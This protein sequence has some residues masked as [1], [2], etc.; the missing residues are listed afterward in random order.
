[1][2]RVRPHHVAVG[3]ALLVAAFNSRTVISAVAPIADRLEDG[4]GLDIATLSIIATL[5]P[6]SFAVFAAVTPLLLRHSGLERAMAM[7]LGAIVLGHFIRALAIDPASFIGG[8]VIGLAGVGTANVLLP[9]LVRRHYGTSVGLLTG[10]YITAQSLGTAL[11]A[12]AGV[13]MSD[14]AGWRVAMGVWAVVGTVG[15]VLWVVVLRGRSVPIAGIAELDPE[16]ARPVGRVWRAPVAWAIAGLF[17]L[18]AS[19][20]YAM[21]S[22]L[23][24]VLVSVAEVSPLQAG[25]LLA[26]FGA[27]GII[28]AMVAPLLAVRIQ[29][30]GLIVMGGFVCLL[31]GYLG[32]LLAPGLLL[33]LWVALLGIGAAFFALCLALV[34]LRTRTH[35]GT[36]VLSSFVQVVGYGAGAV[37]PLAFGLLHEASGSWIVPLVALAA[38]SLVALLAAFVLRRPR[39]L[40][41]E[42]V[43]R[44]GRGA[45]RAIMGG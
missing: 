31:G 15:L 21:L 29:N 17:A 40:E 32:L 14:A 22:W 35:E 24:A 11:P 13:P 34:N 1:M 8:T 7:S 19:H 16:L 6:L 12:L 26:L 38:S 45:T 37:G 20:A 36:V 42:W 2:R 28:P 30:A 18:A 33:V 5:P 41:D 3:A 23:P 27:V 25:S 4:L 10:L 44:P 9:P 39:Y 43:A